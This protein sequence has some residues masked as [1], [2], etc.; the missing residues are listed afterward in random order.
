MGNSS[1][2]FDLGLAFAALPGATAVF[3]A[4]APRFTVVAA[5]DALLAVSHRRRDAVVGRP[6]AE[7]FPNASPADP[8]AGG[9][10]DLRGSLEAAVRTGALQHMPR[11]RY[12]LERPD[13]AW[14]ERYWDAVNTPIPGSDGAVRYVLHQTEDVTARVLGEEALARAEH[15]ARALLARIA[16]AYIVLDRDFRFVDVNPAAERSMRKTREELLGRSHWEAFPASHDVDAGRNYRRAA[17]EGVEL[18][19]TQHYAYEGYDVHLDMDAY[20]TDEGGVAV[21]WRD[22]TARVRAE[23]ER[24]R[25]LAETEAARREAAAANEAKSAF[26][27]TMSHELRTPVNAVLGYAQLLDLG[28]AGPLTEQQRAYLERLAR[29]SRHLLGLVDDVLDLSKI[30]A[31]ET[32]IARADGMTGPA[33]G[34]AL[35]VVAPAAAQRGVR[36]VDGR[37]DEA[38]VPFVGDEDRVRQVAVNLLSNAIKFTAPGGTVTV[39]CDTVRTAPPAATRLRGEGP[40]ALVRVEDTG[41]GIAPEEQGRIFEPFHQVEGGLTRPRGGTGLGLAISRRLAHLMGGDLSVESAP[42]VGSAFTLWLPAARHD[43]GQPTETAAARSARADRELTRLEAPGLAEVGEVLHGAVAEVLAGYTDRL[44]AD[45][46]VPCGAAMT[47]LQLEDHAISFLADLAQSLVIV[48]DAGPEAAELLKAGS[49][50]QRT[51]AAEHGARRHAQGWGEA[52][53]RRDQL[54]F[55]EEVERAVRARLK[56]GSGAVDEAVRV[57]LALVDRG[58]GIAVAAWRRAAHDAAR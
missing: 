45:P 41:I 35:D 40:W 34:A 13:G 37:P 17:Q 46:A 14:E 39:T 29:S 4:D 6:L 50:I 8:E 25:L 47:R 58:Q 16:D 19:F 42:G 1:G 31:G 3:A 44:R 51:I 21:L 12:D 54:V 2:D 55:R 56:A 9:L 52:A 30:E 32:R 20:P 28:L 27:A 33:V 49:A 5:S 7:A 18:H 24:E 15:G 36:L 26:L 23:A 53:L 38:G 11:Q 57:L 43:P 22:V 10:S 48:G